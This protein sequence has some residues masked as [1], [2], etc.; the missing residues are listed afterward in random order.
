MMARFSYILLGAG[1]FALINLPKEWSDR[2]R[3][4]VVLAVAP[5]WQS[6][7]PAMAEAAQSPQIFAHSSETEM[8]QECLAEEKRL[9]SQ[10]EAL[11]QN[12]CLRR[13]AREKQI[14]AMRQVAV[15]ARVIFRDPGSWSSSLWISVGEQDNRTLDQTIVAVNSPVMAANALI[16]MVEYVG[17][18]QSRVRLITDA[19]LVAAVRA[20]RG[21]MQNQ[22]I[23]S[24]V[25]NLLARVQVR[26]D[27]FANLEE[28]QRFTEMLSA[29]QSRL[30]DGEEA[31]MAKGEISGGSAPFFRARTQ[32]LKGTGFNCEFPDEDRPSRDL[33][34][35]INSAP[36]E[37]LIQAGDLLITS[38]LDGL[39]PPGLHVAIATKIMPLKEGSLTYDLEAKPAAG[40][41]LDLRVVFVLPPMN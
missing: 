30:H 24:Q 39:F 11:S 40:D 3:S 22:E 4:N 37:P 12:S 14:V 18:T 17:E 21:G 23:F 6:V 7:C 32:I 13:I 28:K 31:E 10:M 26:D 29:F 15:P 16:G 25:Q 5:I 34:S 36:K 27:L 8:K 20:L 33:R 19:G 2:W 9:Q 41:L 38:G 35:G 1:L